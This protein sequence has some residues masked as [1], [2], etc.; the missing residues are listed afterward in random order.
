MPVGIALV[1]L[2]IVVPILRSGIPA[3][4]AATRTLIPILQ[5]LQKRFALKR[6]VIVA[7]RGLLSLDNVAALE[8]LGRARGESVDYIPISIRPEIADQETCWKV[9]LRTRL[10]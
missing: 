4:V 5:R 10:R 7:D 9:R 8:E 2:A 3:M 6:I 1:H